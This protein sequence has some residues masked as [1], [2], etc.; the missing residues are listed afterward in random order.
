MAYFRCCVEK[1]GNNMGTAYIVAFGD[2]V[3]ETISVRGI[4]PKG[5]NYKFAIMTEKLSA[6]GSNTVGANPSYDGH[7]ASVSSSFNLPTI[8]YDPDQEIVTM[9]QTKILGSGQG[10]G[11]GNGSCNAYTS[12]SADI[13][14]VLAYTEK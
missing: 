8:T 7:R 5:K 2:Q 11:S 9:S 13:I 10:S 14:A 1:T 12:Y 4:L 6:G 3:K